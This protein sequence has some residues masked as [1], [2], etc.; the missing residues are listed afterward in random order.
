MKRSSEALQTIREC[1]IT[2][3]ISVMK[4]MASI[5]GTVVQRLMELVDNSIDAKVDGV[6][7]QVDVNVVKKERGSYIEIIDNGIGMTEETAD[8][9][10]RL[11]GSQKQGKIGKFGMGAKVAILGLGN[12]CCITSYPKE[13]SYAVRMS[14]DIATFKEWNLKYK[15]SQRSEREQGKHGT[16]IRI[17]HLS[18]KM[19]SVEKFCE[20]VSEH[21]AKVY[22]HYIER[23]DVMIRVN[24]KRVKAKAL[25]LLPHLFQTFDFETSSGKRVYGWA[26]AT[27]EAGVNWRF[28]FDLIQR[29]RVIVM[30]DCLKRQHH[31]SLTRL[32]GD[33]HL[34]DFAVDI[35][36]GAFL[37]E[38]EE[39]EEMQEHLL[40]VELAGLIA[41]I[42]KLTNKEVYVKHQVHM[43]QVSKLLNRVVS[44]PT[45]LE[46]LEVESGVFGVLKKR[47]KRSVKAV[48]EFQEEVD[49][50]MYQD[51]SFVFEDIE[52]TTEELQ[53]QTEQEEQG[54]SEIDVKSSQEQKPKGLRI[55]EP[56]A[57]AAG[58]HQPSRRWITNSYG[59]RCELVVEVNLD[60]PSYRME[61]DEAVALHMQQALID[62]LAEF[63]LQEEKENGGCFISEIE[64]LNEIKDVIVRESLKL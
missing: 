30:N 26:G 18:I 55:R 39:F 3:D 14:F 56:I 28:G 52:L 4:N 40:E 45:F 19:G 6:P 50:L 59:N 7:L 9:Y 10:F 60:H 38:T 58:E 46:H 44:R 42:A 25:E 43:N 15:V 62:S 54:I 29:G 41:N 17:D 22:R 2:P 34:D 35:H 16:K 33:I 31:T 37:R 8:S 13:E 53:M 5:S 24:K 61:S 57:I 20:R 64:R 21:F 36:K 27:K 1:D 47:G 63:V 12:A 49:E 32:A 48:K 51:I 23:G 11:G